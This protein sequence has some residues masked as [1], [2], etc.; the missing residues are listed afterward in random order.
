MTLGAGLVLAGVVD[1]SLR[2]LAR[3]VAVGVGW[4]PSVWLLSPH[5]VVVRLPGLC[6]YP[7]GSGSTGS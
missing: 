1:V 6:L 3:G 5:G 4:G 7:P 2:L